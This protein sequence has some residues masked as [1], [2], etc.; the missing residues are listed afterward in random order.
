[1]SRIPAEIHALVPEELKNDYGIYWQEKSSRYYVYRDLGNPYDPVKKRS[2]SKRVNLGSIKDGAFKYSPSYLKNL[3]VARLK[4]ELAEKNDEAVKTVEETVQ[5]NG[6]K[7]LVKTIRNAV[8]SVEEVRQEAKV[9]YPLEVVL[10]VA[11]LAACAGYTSSVSIALYWRQNRSELE[12]LLGEF[13]EKDISHDTVNRLLKLIDPLKFQQLLVAVATPMIQKVGQRVFHFDGQAIKGSKTPEFPHGRFILG[14]F[15]STNAVC[16]QAKLIESKKNEISEAINL[17]EM[18]DLRPGDVVTADA[19][20]TQK[21]LVAYLHQRNV[22]YC[23]ALKEN[24]PTFTAEVRSL[25]SGTAD[26]SHVKTFETK[27]VD[28]N[29]IE[30]R[31]YKVIDGRFLSKPL[32]E[33][34]DGLD[35]GCL[36]ETTTYSEKKLD[37]TVGDER[38]SCHTRYFI[39][40]IDPKQVSEERIAEIIRSHWSIE[41]KMHWCLDNPF[42]QDRIQCRDANYLQNRVCLNKIGLNAIRGIQKVIKQTTKQNYSIK[43][44]QQLC[45]TAAGAVELLAQVDDLPQVLGAEES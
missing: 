12:M 42:N 34:W 27:D 32:K 1:M 37:N 29:R 9:E 5:E 4:K 23:L 33:A 41:N 2:V 28:H 22:H 25:F 17:L 13:P 15:E 11:L 8:E 45:N 10:F 14:A 35:K 24:H 7:G 26:V 6:Q 43:T 38:P 36:I 31:T 20:H 30:R 16:L 18:M 44:T 3:E 40:S 21:K 19:M 39:S